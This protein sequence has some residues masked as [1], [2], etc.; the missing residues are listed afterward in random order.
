[1]K[2]DANVTREQNHSTEE[3]LEG[4]RTGHPVASSSKRTGSARRIELSSLTWLEIHS[5][6]RP[7]NIDKSVRKTTAVMKIGGLILMQIQT[8]RKVARLTQI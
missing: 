8:H 6:K 7:E 5:A 4:S 2:R 1:M 3:P